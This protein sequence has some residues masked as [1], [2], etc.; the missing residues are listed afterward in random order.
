MAVCLEKGL[1]APSGSLVVGSQESIDESRIW[2][3]RMGGGMRQVGILAATGLHALDHHIERL[4][5]DH[6]NAAL[7]AAAIGPTAPTNIV[8][9]SAPDAVAPV[10]AARE[11]G[12]WGSAGGT[13]PVRT[14]THPAMRMHAR[15]DKGGA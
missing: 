12:V 14:F 6:A 9:A 15:R 3:K 2:R 5:Q 4:A 10:A 7:L 11:A 13:T 8:V 1:G